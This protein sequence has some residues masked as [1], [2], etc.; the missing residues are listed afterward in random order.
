M[1]T[2]NIHDAKTH[3]SRLV[4]EEFIIAKTG[5]PVARVIPIGPDA[6][7]R[8]FGFMRGQ[9]RVPDNFDELDVDEIADLFGTK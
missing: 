9:I 8:R 3:L 1:K 4:N 6:G 7:E 2:M 5:K